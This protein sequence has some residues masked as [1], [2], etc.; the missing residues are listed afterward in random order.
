MS[1]QATRLRD[2]VQNKTNSI[3]SDSIT[4]NSNNPFKIITVTSGKGGVGKSNFT[5]N[6]AMAFKHHGKSSLILDADFG[7]SNIDLILGQ[8]PK[9]NLAHLVQD[10]LSMKEIITYTP[11]DIPFISGGTGV[12]EMLFL[13]KFQLERIALELSGLSEL[14][15]IL[16]ID[17]GAGI[18][19]TVI[20]FSEMADDVCLIITPDPS[21]ITDAYALLKT[22][23]KDFK[24]NPR[25]TVVLNRV[26]SEEEAQIVYKKI[27][28][29]AESFLKIKVG[30]GGYIPFDTQLVKAVKQQ[31][32][33]FYANKFAPSSIEYNNVACKLLNITSSEARK[34]SLVNK[35]KRI[36]VK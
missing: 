31:Q 17:T 21:S 9:Y 10:K 30:Y 6:L 19:D 36:L 5:A 29:A 13:D 27:A 1:D 23:T 8:R 2:M 4:Y 18:N 32:P 20:K 35:L 3:N 15:D 34:E 22:F 7:L 14:T 28:T 26:D 24:I 16:L 11:Y 12:K 25:F 33:I